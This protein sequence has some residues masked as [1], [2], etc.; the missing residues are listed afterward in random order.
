MTAP[1]KYPGSGSE[2][3]VQGSVL[4]NTME[5][6]DTKLNH[7]HYSYV[8]TIPEFVSPVMLNYALR[9]EYKFPSLI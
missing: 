8:K 1:A 7:F 3:L 2:T 4:E 5:T 6:M 9:K